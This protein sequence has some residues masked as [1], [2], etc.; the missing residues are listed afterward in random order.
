[1]TDTTLAKTGGMGLFERYLT[2]WVALAMIVG[3][4]IGTL[5][6]GLVEAVSAAEVASINL[7]VAV[8]IWAMIYPMMVGVD[9]RT[10]SEVARQPKGLILTL[11]V[12]W[13]IKPF[14]MALLAVLF[15][16]FVFAPWISP[17][18]A[19]QY[20]M[21]TK[22]APIPRA[23]MKRSRP[24]TTFLSCAIS[25]SSPSASGRGRECRPDRSSSPSP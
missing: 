17:E 13:L 7:V 18:D 23:R 21:V 20:M 22:A 25:A 19:A 11:V 3:L 24:S 5:A 12:N 2:L 14:T 4:T 8:L 16:D 15:F 10:V 1:M 6:P 9:F